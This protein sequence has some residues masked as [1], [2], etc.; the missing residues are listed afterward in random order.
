M[1]PEKRS[2]IEGLLPKQPYR[3]V[4]TLLL[5]MSIWLQPNPDI[6]KAQN[7]ETQ[8]LMA[9][10]FKKPKSVVRRDIYLWDKRVCRKCWAYF[11]DD[12]HLRLIDPKGH[13]SIVPYRDIV[14]VDYHPIWRKLV[15]KSAHGIGVAGPALVPSSFDNFAD[16]ICKYCDKNRYNMSVP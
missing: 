12:E 4:G 15:V 13:W 11:V 2:L 9:S 3:Y 16:Y 5:A 6:V 14:G 7:N 10:T 8:P 1:P